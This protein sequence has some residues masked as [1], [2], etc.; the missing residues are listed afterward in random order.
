MLVLKN[1]F[2][3]RGGTL[4]FAFLCVFSLSVTALPQEQVGQL[5]ELFAA[6]EGGD[7]ERA[8]LV[9]H[10][11]EALNNG[12]QGALPGFP[13]L[14]KL[15]A[16]GAESEGAQGGK[17]K[18]PA[19]DK[20]LLKVLKRYAPPA[21]T[22]A[23]RAER[24]CVTPTLFE[25]DSLVDD[26]T[27]VLLNIGNGI[28]YP[29]KTERARAIAG[30]VHRFLSNDTKRRYVLLAASVMHQLLVGY[31][32]YRSYTSQ[33]Y[34]EV[35]KNLEALR[36]GGGDKPA[37]EAALRAA[38][39]KLG[40][41]D[42]LDPLL[43]ALRRRNATGFDLKPVEDLWLRQSMYEYATGVGLPPSALSAKVALSGVRAIAS[44]TYLA[45]DVYKK[46]DEL[47]VQET[48]FAAQIEGL[49]AQKYRELEAKTAR[50]L[51]PLSVARDIFRGSI[52]YNGALSFG[53]G[54]RLP[55]ASLMQLAA[56]AIT[57]WRVGKKIKENEK[58]GTGPHML[59]AFFLRHALLM[60]GT[61]LC[62]AIPVELDEKMASGLSE[63]E[64]EERYF[65]S[66]GFL[67]PGM[68]SEFYEL[69]LRKIHKSFLAGW[70][71]PVEAVEERFN[72]RSM[73]KFVA[74]TVVT[75]LLSRMVRAGIRAERWAPL[76]T[77][78]RRGVRWVLPDKVAS[79]FSTGPFMSSCFPDLFAVAFRRALSP[80]AYA[81]MARLFEVKTGANIDLLIAGLERMS[82]EHVVRSIG[83]GGY[84]K[85]GEI[86]HVW[87]SGVLTS[88]QQEAITNAFYQEVM[89]Y[90]LCSPRS[91][92]PEIAVGWLADP[93]AVNPGRGAGNRYVMGRLAQA[94]VTKVIDA[95]A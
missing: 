74:V 94:L 48:F 22:E 26:E 41:A 7:A 33:E 89:A 55:V 86:E 46:I 68:W 78:L 92:L 31:T 2:N 52:A 82:F 95:V 16:E 35:C 13:D 30:A 87:T 61:T 18:K 10:L 80:E 5:G 54:S 36:A 15:F 25:R 83:I 19:Q 59:D 1:F 21:L 11:V 40:E 43:D 88:E 63:R 67:R 85:S 56:A 44:L 73:M 91:Y 39:H 12:G 24:V 64:R 9:P 8:G 47:K 75:A 42:Q 29:F 84:E 90:F 53:F 32:T 69:G 4:L 77:R 50:L 76:I 71:R 66:Q 37:V 70:G 14:M 62:K 65:M 38:L 27:D 23:E 6:P 49:D 58:G 72:R 51:E 3:K 60:C 57:A 93:L 17:K 79:F 20:A 34:R 81:D 45:A 28:L